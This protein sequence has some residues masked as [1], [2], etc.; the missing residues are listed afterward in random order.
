ML[1][2][3]IISSLFILVF[4]FIWRVRKSCIQKVTVVFAQQSVCLK[5]RQLSVPGKQVAVVGN[6]VAA[7]MFTDVRWNKLNEMQQLQLAL[8]LCQKALPVWEKYTAAKEVAYRSSTTGPLNKIDNKILGTA[9]DEI[10]LSSQFQFPDKDNKKII[11]CYSHFVSGVLAMQD[12]IWSPSYPVKKIFLAVYSILK[13]IVEQNNY[14]GTATILSA[15]INQ[16]LDCIDIAKLY[17]HHEIDCFLE[18]YKNKI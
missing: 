15:A 3:I 18:V 9:I 16:A 12:G 5:A 2:V 4:L 10:V 1:I 6:P 17:T 7:M 8:A 13:S 11:N 14:C